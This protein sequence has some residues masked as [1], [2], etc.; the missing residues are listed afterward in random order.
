MDGSIGDQQ[1]GGCKGCRVRAPQGSR[2]PQSL[3]EGSDRWQA[4]GAVS[5]GSPLET[6]AVA[7]RS[8]RPFPAA[9][10]TSATGAQPGGAFQA[11]RRRCLPASM[12]AAPTDRVS[13]LL[14]DQDFDRRPKIRR[15]QEL[16]KRDRAIPLR[17][18]NPAIECLLA[19]ADRKSVGAAAKRAWSGVVLALAKWHS[20]AL[21]DD[22]D[23]DR[24]RSLDHGSGNERSHRSMSS[25]LVHALAGAFGQPLLHLVAP[26]ADFYCR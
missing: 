26:P 16:Y 14:A 20:G 10:G 15:M 17:T 7:D 8:R 5:L 19:Y 2:E 13:R 9:G 3:L 1:P 11:L 18:T 21:R 4:K 23:V 25:S 22:C 12:F 6:R 24:V